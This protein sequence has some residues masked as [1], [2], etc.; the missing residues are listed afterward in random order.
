M[1]TLPAVEDAPT[2]VI[3]LYCDES[4]HLERD[5]ASVMTLGAMWLPDGVARRVAEDLRAIKERCGLPR[6]FEAK[7][8]K[9]SPAG[10][11]LYRDLIQYFL[12]NDDLNFRALVAHGKDQLDHAAFHQDHDT[13]YY[14]MYFEMLRVLIDTDRRY[15]IYLDIKDTLGGPKVR[16]LHEILANSIRD[17]DLRSLERL[18]IV[19]SHEVEV[20]QLV[21]LLV[22]AATYANR[23]LKTSP[24][25]LALIEQIEQGAGVRLT[26]NTSL[27]DTKVNLFHWKPQ[28]QW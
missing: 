25:K 6:T 28:G 5:G 22:G 12:G 10:L 1:V 8:T 11:D 2:A 18:Q 3:N 15:R 14:K 17:F 24:A 27:T 23:G 16:R 19:R 9:V 13:W 21:D 7:W 20:L 4:C 26:R